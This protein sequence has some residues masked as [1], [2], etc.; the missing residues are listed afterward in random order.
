MFCGAGGTSVRGAQWA[1]SFLLEVYT[2][3]FKAAS[4]AAMVLEATA[5]EVAPP[6]SE[7]ADLLSLLSAKMS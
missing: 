1:L 6:A 7:T 5:E 2:R 4:V 3:S